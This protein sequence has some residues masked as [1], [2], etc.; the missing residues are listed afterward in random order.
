MARVVREGLLEEAAFVLRLG[1]SCRMNPGTIWGSSVVGGAQQ[2]WSCVG[3]GPACF[4]RSKASVAE[5]TEQGQAGRRG[6]RGPGGGRVAV[7]WR[8][9]AT[10]LTYGLFRCPLLPHAHLGI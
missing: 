8:H 4:E 7:V 9:S 1:R 2:Q 6:R 10:F 3:K 5:H